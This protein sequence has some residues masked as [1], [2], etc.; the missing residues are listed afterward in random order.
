MSE[1][2][3]RLLVFALSR[4][5]EGRSEERGRRERKQ[6]GARLMD[7]CGLTT[8]PQGRGSGCRTSENKA[9]YSLV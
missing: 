8:L 6:E 2:T 9:Y 3:R 7:S 4:I 1:N 5:R